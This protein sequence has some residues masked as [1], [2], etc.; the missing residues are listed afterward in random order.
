M[1]SEKVKVVQDQAKLGPIICVFQ[2]Q[3]KPCQRTGNPWK[4]QETLPVPKRK[5]VWNLENLFFNLQAPKMKQR[6]VISE[7]EFLTT[8]IEQNT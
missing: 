8:W 5:P 3:G 4:T 2:D 1:L 7:K 6:S